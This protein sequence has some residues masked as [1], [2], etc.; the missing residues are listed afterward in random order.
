MIE[1][2]IT[3]LT[4][5][6]FKYTLAYKVSLRFITFFSINHQVANIRLKPRSKGLRIKFELKSKKT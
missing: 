1:V 5:H 2:C 6:M 4:P 3:N